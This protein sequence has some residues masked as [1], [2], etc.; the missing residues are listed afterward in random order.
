M[1]C[2]GLTQRQVLAHGTQMARLCLV[3]LVALS[4]TVCSHTPVLQ[5]CLALLLRTCGMRHT[6][7]R[8]NLSTPVS[9]IN[10]HMQSNSRHCSPTT[11]AA[12]STPVNYISQAPLLLTSSRFGQ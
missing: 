3:K 6:R 2:D 12:K 5:I 11:R 8:S 1:P 9:Y 7:G 10:L 4:P